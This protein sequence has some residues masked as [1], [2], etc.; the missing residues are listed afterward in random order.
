MKAW[1]VRREGEPG[2]VLSLEEFP[3]PTPAHLADLEFDMAGW[4][5][6][7]GTFGNDDPDERELF[8]R[9][10]ASDRSSTCPPG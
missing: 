1:M 5:T 8:A 7:P 2:E 3:E 4:I 9:R 6:D 10:S